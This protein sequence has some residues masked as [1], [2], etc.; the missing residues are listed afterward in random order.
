MAKRAVPGTTPTSLNKR[1][2]RAKA[3]Y[4]LLEMI[5]ALAIMGL[6]AAVIV[7]RGAAA[8]DQVVV[9]SVFFDFQ[10]QISDLR[11]TA[12]ADQRSYDL[13]SSQGTPR[14]QIVILA[15]DTDDSIQKVTIPL[16]AGWQYRVSQPIRISSGGLCSGGAVDLINLGHV[17]AHLESHDGACH[18]LRIN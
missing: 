2:L 3:G 14:A 10:R 8:L 13:E 4:S 11:A 7:P 18:F 16:R 6:A 12:F 9:H 17:A 1:P 15:P 5:I